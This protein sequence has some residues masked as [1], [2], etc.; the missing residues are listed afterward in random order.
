MKR[1]IQPEKTL[2]KN[3][4]ETRPTKVHSLG[5]VVG[6]R[7]LESKSGKQHG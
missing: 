1:R 2:L 7:V 4:K 6:N 3:A 5:E